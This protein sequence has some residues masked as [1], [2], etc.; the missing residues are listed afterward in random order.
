MAKGKLEVISPSHN[1]NISVREIDNGYI[2]SRSTYNKDGYKSCETY[3]CEKPKL[4][5]E[6]EKPKAKAKTKSGISRAM[7][8][9]GK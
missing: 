1:E 6:A 2:T 4:I 3:S 8:Y 9:L 5:M 7:K